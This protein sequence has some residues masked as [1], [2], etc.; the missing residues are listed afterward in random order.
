MLWHMR[1]RMASVMAHEG[2]GRWG[3]WDMLGSGDHWGKQRGVWLLFVLY[4]CMYVGCTSVIYHVTCLYYQHTIQPSSVAPTTSTIEGGSSHAESSSSAPFGVIGP[5]RRS[6]MPNN[7]SGRSR[8]LGYGMW[9]STHGQ[10]L[11]GGGG[12]GGGGGHSPRLEG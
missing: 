6:S 10:L 12:G 4:A 9:A 1:E 11:R 2:R 3:K 5:P 8:K 7:T